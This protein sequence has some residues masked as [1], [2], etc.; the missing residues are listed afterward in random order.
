MQVIDNPDM[1]SLKRSNG[2]PDQLA[3]C[4]TALID[5]YVVEGHVP[6]EAI[7]RLLRAKPAD[8]A[9]IA[10]PGMPRGS[11]GMEVPDGTR[12]AFE[13]IAYT[14]DGRAKPFG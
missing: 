4:H 13:V 8:V 6:F 11:P 2:V 10:V 3:S 14:K 5:G 9:G 12:D 7:E 1:A